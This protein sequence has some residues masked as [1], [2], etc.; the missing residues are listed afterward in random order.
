M[1][2]NQEQT[3]RGFTL[4][5][6]MILVVILGVLASMGATAYQHQIHHAKTAE[7]RTMLGA[8]QRGLT[9]AFEKDW[10]KSE[11]LELGEASSTYGSEGSKVTGGGSGSSGSGNGKGKGKGGGNGGGA[12]VVHDGTVQLCGGADPVPDSI[13]KVK[14][15]KYQSGPEWDEGDAFTGWPCMGF[16]INTPQYYQ[17]GYDVGGPKVQVTLPKG[18]N[19]PGLDKDFTYTAWA[20]GDLDGDG[21]TSWF[22]TEGAVMEG[23]L[24]HATG[25]GITDETE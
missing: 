6:L 19:P 20:R 15:A 24:V 1:R 12:T 13:N 25:I 2:G 9:I 17:Y 16:R 21:R 3:R 10:T 5:E 11:V 8:M 23:R 4:V 22:V 14:R 18:G 7:P